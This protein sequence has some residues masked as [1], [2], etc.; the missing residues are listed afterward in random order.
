MAQKP[1]TKSAAEKNNPNPKPSLAARRALEW[2][3]SLVLLADIFK[4]EAGLEFARLLK[5]LAKEE[6]DPSKGS[7]RWGKL[8][9]ALVERQEFIDHPRVGTILQDYFLERFLENDNP[10][11]RKAELATLSQIGPSLSQA[12]LGEL[13]AV[14][15]LLKTDWEAEYLGKSG[16]M[17]KGAP[18]SLESARGLAANQPLSPSLQARVAIKKTILTSAKGNPLLDEV[19]GHFY[20][21]GWGL[22]G[23]FRAYRWE[24]REG[25]G[26]LV[27]I[28]AVDPI[29]LENLVG[30]DEQRRPLIENIEA[31]VAGKPANNA[32]L[33]GER[34]TGKSSTVKALLN[35]YQE[36]GLRLVE[37][38][39]RELGEL[40]DIFPRLR[41]RREKFILFVDDL[42]FE[43]DETSYKGLKALMEGTV[44][45]TPGNVILIA[46]SN[47][48]HLIREFFGDRAGGFQQE[49]EIHGA[50]TVEEK[51]SLADRFGLVI[52]FYTPD[53]ETYFK[54]VDSWAKAEGIK[55]KPEELHA[56]AVQ[57][58]KS[59]NVRSG[60]TA[61]QFINDLKGKS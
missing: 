55:I 60:R 8:W 41:G 61:R 18:P 16:L 31:F 53:Q 49:G 38:A 25:K 14:Q 45:A 42:S 7:R 10:F 15:K 44:E 48:R 54:M 22:F 39:P 4:D 23:R 35:Q 9:L 20:Q 46:T 52:S 19:A 21:I 12:Y 28:A 32:L 36:R 56:R 58:E 13:E 29:R 50:D 27:G 34:G 17:G 37:V 43:E 26:E 57:W 2:L 1:K 11:H 5:W 6:R 51:L 59:N 47:R 30:Y 24:D 3:D 33:Y 40:H